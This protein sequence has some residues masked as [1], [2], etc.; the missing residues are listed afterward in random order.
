M[1]KKIIAGKYTIPDFV[2]K[3]AK[4]LIKKILETNPKKRVT[5]PE[6]KK[7]KWFNIVESNVH[8]GIDTRVNVIP[9]DEEIVTKMESLEYNKEEVRSNV[10]MNEH[11]HITTT[12]YLLLKKKSRNHIPSVSDLKSED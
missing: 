1:Y 4:D 3:P 9:I 5:I 2:S 10:M 11:N 12:Y 6:I 7:H 8:S